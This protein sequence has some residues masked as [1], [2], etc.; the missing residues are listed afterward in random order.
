M[1]GS[2]RGEGGRAGVFVLCQG[3][4]AC[5]SDAS[6][7]CDRGGPACVQPTRAAGAQCE[8][9]LP[10]TEALALIAKLAL[11]PLT[12]GVGAARLEGT[13]CPVPILLRNSRLNLGGVGTACALTCIR[14]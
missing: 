14:N 6:E 5:V 12:H 9:P 8:R 10:V 3:V 7:P 2:H 1:P 4:S 13:P 11:G